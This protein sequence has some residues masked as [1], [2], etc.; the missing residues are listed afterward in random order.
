M[1]GNLW[2]WRR[3]ELPSE[4]TSF[5]GRQ[6]E[7]DSV[8]ALL[9]S[10]RMVTLLG[11]G[12]VG[13]TR[14]A[15]RAAISLAGGFRD[16]VRMVELSGVKDGELLPHAVGAA[17]GLPETAGQA[18]LDMVVEFLREEQ[19]LLI[20]DTCEHLVDSCAMLAE[21]LLSSCPG[22][23]LLLTS[24]HTLDVPAEHTLVVSPLE[25]AE[26]VRLFTERAVAVRP[27]FALTAGNHDQVSALCR[28]LDGIPLALELAA[29]RLRALPLEQV[30]RRLE[31]RFRVLG[32]GR[33]PHPRHQTLRTA[34]DWSHELCT[35]GERAL[36]ARLSVFAGGFDLD[37]VEQV[38]A[39]G[40]LDPYDIVDH[41]IGLVD[42]SIVIRDEGEGDDRYRMLDT[43]REYGSEQL[44]EF[45]ESEAFARRHRDHF[46]RLAREGHAA[47]FGPEQVQWT[48]RFDREID[49]FRTAMEWSLTTP[50]E[51]VGAVALAGSLAGL[52]IGRGRLVEGLRWGDRARA[53]G[54]GGPRDRGVLGFM[55]ATCMILNGD[56]EGAAEEYARAAEDSA[57]AGDRRGRG[58][59]L[60]FLSAALAHVGRVE[61]AARVDEEVGLIARELDDGYIL[62]MHYRN[63]GDQHFLR[64]DTA[65][66]EAMMLRALEALPR[67][68]AWAVAITH[69]FLGVVQIMR[70]NVDGAGEHGRQCVRDMARLPDLCGVNNALAV[71]VWVAAAQGRNEDAARLDGA[72]AGIRRG[73]APLLINDPGLLGLHAKFREEA[74]KALGEEEFAKFY[75]QGE[76]LGLRQAVAFALGEPADPLPDTPALQRPTLAAL[77]RREREVAALVQQGLSNR[78]IAES[79]VISKRTADAHVEHILAKLG[80]ASRGEV[81][82]LVRAEQER[83]RT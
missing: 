5:I 65:A 37:A 30:L 51:E 80:V 21:I 11:P 38:C 6:A 34:I 69:F 60:M 25:E 73:V 26:A 10:A 28:R 55:R 29:V 35:P 81:A 1:A 56:R 8:R 32:G 76:A 53:T 49:N 59:N 77:T 63:V 50:G 52:W 33:G 17:F 39:D 14:I 4:T 66:A 64:G 9:G 24:R 62:G 48:H 36:W 75:A 27:G 22:L 13:K 19:S 12:G 61:D 71:L 83:T 42:K 23:R 44:A 3:G 68:E 45:G 67:G 74:E 16:G 70:G 47:W 7:I 58:M 43:I 20:L 78:Q 46:L 82:A 72:A 57:E 2:N 79:L 15:V 41:L 54:A 40:D 18:P 31:D